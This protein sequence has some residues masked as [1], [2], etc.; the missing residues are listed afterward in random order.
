MTT[1]EIDFRSYEADDD[2][3]ERLLKAV[4]PELAAAGVD[5]EQVEFKSIV[6]SGN[7][8]TVRVKPR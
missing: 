1:V 6:Q 5:T 2:F 7:K 3:S 8:T 4:E